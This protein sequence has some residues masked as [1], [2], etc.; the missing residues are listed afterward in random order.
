MVDVATRRWLA[1]KI[2]SQEEEPFTF[3]LAKLQSIPT[4]LQISCVSTLSFSY[5][6]W[7]L[8]SS[9]YLPQLDAIVLYQ[10]EPGLYVSHLT[11]NQVTASSYEPNKIIT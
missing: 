11:Q 4:E 3:V 5:G 7:Q 9:L 8:D 1:H 10:D 2:A 6:Y